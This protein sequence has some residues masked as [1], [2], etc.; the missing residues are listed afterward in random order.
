MKRFFILIVKIL[1]VLG[2]A[3][4]VLAV[5]FARKWA[6]RPEDVTVP[7]PT[8]IAAPAVE[9]ASPAPTAPVPAA[10]T[11]SPAPT[12]EPTPSPTPS[13]TPEPTPIVYTI[14]AVGDCTLAS[15]PKIRNWET[16]FESVVNGDWSYPTRN[17]LD[18]LGQD[19]LTI[20]NLECSISDIQA[21]SA[22][23][24]SFL[25]PAPAVGILTEGSVECVTAANNHALDFGRAVYDD[26]IANLQ[27]AGIS[28]A[29]EG[30][31]V[32]CTTES[33]LRVG[34]YADFNGHYPTAEKVTA[35]VRSLLD[36]GAEAVVVCLHWGDEASYYQN[37]SQ[38]QTAHAA[39]DAGAC[40]VFGHGPHRVQPVEEYNG[41]VI[42][43]SL[44]NFIFGGNTQPEDMDTVIGQVTIV[45]ELDG[46]IRF[47]GYCVIPCSISSQSPMN[48]YCPT[49][50][51]ENSDGYMRALSKANGSWT[52]ANNVIDYSFM[53][54]DEG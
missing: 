9:K 31:G 42:F 15:Y 46:T 41:G 54:P 39:I 24:F 30:E 36:Q 38:V 12:P 20:A 6:A 25:A 40:A 3:A 14:S 13:P 49:P 53:H 10:P 34:V 44:A 29:G 43:Y 4:L 17:T 11:A 27:N 50:W 7:A 22:S 33:G 48:D 35:G 26:T 16:S 47:D 51:E 32:I 5:L 23:T 8:P 18:I 21:Y 52:G 37:G 45:R 19:D 28:T 2:L 1:A